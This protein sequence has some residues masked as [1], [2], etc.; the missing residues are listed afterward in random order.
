MTRIAAA[1]SQNSGEVPAAQPSRRE[2][3]KRG[4]AW[5]MASYVAQQVLRLGNHLV[6]AYLLAP[7]MFGIMAKVNVFLAGIQ[8]FADLGIGASVIQHKRGEDPLFVN[9]AWTV[10][11]LRGTSL[12]A[13]MCILAWPYAKFYGSPELAAYV[14]AASL[15]PLVTSFSSMSIFQLYRRLHL[16]KIAV[17]ELSTQFFGVVVMTVWALF[18]KSVWPLIAG[19]IGMALFRSIASRYIT[20]HRDRFAW[21]ADAWKALRHFGLSIFLSTALMFLADQSATLLLGKYVTDFHLGLYSAAL[22]LAMMGKTA[23]TKV[24]S[25]VVFPAFSILFRENP[26]RAVHHYARSQTLI[27]A[28]ATLM[29]AACYVLAPIAIPI[30]YMKSP[31]FHQ[32]DWM[33]QALGILSACEVMRSPASWLLLAAGK[34]QYSVWG[35]G[36]RFATLLVGIP[37][38]MFYADIK[39]AI[40]VIALSGVPTFLVF[41]WGVGRQFP[42][43][44]A[45]ERLASVWVL[46]AC[47]GVAVLAFW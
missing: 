26:S 7:D 16:G 8:M 20:E 18:D 43:L 1:D 33:L 42:E 21:D 22:G 31:K 25:D 10:E 14:C 6:M 38:A 2:L 46:I 19:S 45:R 24:M 36:A 41:S 30:L 12:T 47:A 3:A 29:G 23:I 44:A 27:A 37:M 39:V 28:G 13:I 5:S 17:L 32:M 15:Q 9:T 4:F 11:V 35:N 34:P 40:W